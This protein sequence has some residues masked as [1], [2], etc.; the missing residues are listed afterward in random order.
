MSKITR[1]NLMAGVAAASAVGASAGTALA[2]AA[3]QAAKRRF[4]LRP[5]M[6]NRT[7]D[8]LNCRLRAYNGQIPGPLLKVKGGESLTVRVSNALP[9]YDSAGWRGDHNVPHKLDTTNL[10]FHGLDV[11]PHLFAPLGTSNPL[12]RMIAIAP[13]RHLD[14]PLSLPQDHPPGLYWYHPHHH[15]STAVQAVSGMAGPIIVTG[16]IDEVPEIKAAR[17]IPLVVQD[18]GLFPDGGSASP[19]Y[20]YTPKQNDIWQTFGGNVTKYDPHSHKMEP[21]PGA[22]SGFTTG[23]YPVR[24]FL[25]N[26][27]P[28]FREDHNASNNECSAGFTGPRCPTP[29]QLPV[30]RISI[31]PGEVVRFRMLNG[32]SD[33]LMPLRVEGHDVHMLALDGRNFERVRTIPGVVATNT[34]PQFTLAPANRA[35][36]LI[37]G[38]DRPGIYRIL[39][40]PQGEQFLYSAGKVVA[41]IEVT[42]SPNRNMALPTALPT[43]TRYYPLIKPDEVKRIRKFQFS[44][45]FPG[46]LNPE[47]GIDF[48]INN[49]L[50]DETAVPTV[51]YLNDVEEWHL[52]VGDAKEGGTEGHPFHIHLNGFE[53]IAVGDTRQPPG[54][55][56]DTVW[57]P[58]NTVVKVRMR[59]KEFTGKSVFHCHILPHEDTG[60]MQ[61]FLV[62]RRGAHRH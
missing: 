13:G 29:K 61:N 28:F 38:N 19:T 23:D 1:R 11:A 54:T 58:Q 27:R 59:F 49:K 7:L 18:I 6:V 21:A 15:G 40:T 14:Y 51:V 50:Y 12:A 33:N 46:V 60:M 52:I 16:P 62:L 5:G 41:E 26:G 37:K 48:K 9:P 8:G 34:A 2:Q 25:L 42:N 22:T 55:I 45:G 32:C 4:D 56:L 20:S 24:F 53:V 36:F 47:V 44:G 10:H 3:A 17:D 57:I 30:Q 43:I 31:A 35:E 39:Q